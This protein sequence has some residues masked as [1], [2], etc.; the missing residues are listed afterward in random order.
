[1]MNLG[2]LL[3]IALAMVY[4]PFALILAVV[5]TLTWRTEWKRT[6]RHRAHGDV[7]E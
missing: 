2:L 6:G 7:A 3:V 1:M 4:V 5:F